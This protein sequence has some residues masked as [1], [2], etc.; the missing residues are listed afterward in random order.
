MAVLVAEGLTKIYGASKKTAI[1]KA[2][3]GLSLQ[4][5]AGEMVGVMGPSGSGKTTLLNILATIDR[6]TSGSFRLDGVDP[7]TLNG[8]EL[9]RFRR[10]VLGYVFQ[11]FNL[12]K[13]LNVQDNIAL[14]LA[15]D[16]VSSK[17]IKKRL[18][19]VAEQLDLIPLLQ[20]RI[21]E[22]SGGQQQRVAIARAIV[23]R[24]ALILAD[25]PTGNLDS[26]SS[27]DVLEA[28]VQLNKG[29]GATV[30]MV[31]HDPF[32]ASFCQRIIFIRDGQL[33]FELRRKETRQV[34]FQEIL[35]T[36][37]LLGGDFPNGKERKGGLHW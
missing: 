2:L 9:A 15:L 26:K 24:P 28:F 8:E 3:S 22:L 35:D 21:Y 11:D 14:P 1:T 29:E 10:R 37:S 23:H 20:R 33:F 19:E 4:V 30:L 32:V 5:E 27:W 12:L 36:L 34:F 16:G 17:K 18:T 7:T 6:P 13:T 25:E 31:T